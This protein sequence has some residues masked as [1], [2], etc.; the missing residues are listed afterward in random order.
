[1]IA[2]FMKKVDQLNVE[3]QDKLPINEDLWKI[4]QGNSKANDD[5]QESSGEDQS[6]SRSIHLLKK[7][8]LLVSATPKQQSI[9]IQCGRHFEGLFTI[10]N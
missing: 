6:Q 1:M 2:N 4:M 3:T 9:P 5:I 8:D 10:N 7:S